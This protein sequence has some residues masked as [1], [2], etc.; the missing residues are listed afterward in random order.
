L[1]ERECKGVSRS[2]KNGDPPPRKTKQK[3]HRVHSRENVGSVQ[4]GKKWKGKG[5][6]GG[7]MKKGR[8]I[9]S[10][11]L[12]KGTTLTAGTRNPSSGQ[13]P[14]PWSSTDCLSKKKD[15]G[16]EKKAKNV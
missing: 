14:L 8:K 3:H 5:G 11:N 16:N 1:K 12:T 9:R 10:V 6:K 13:S 15:R 4:S 7:N 2:N